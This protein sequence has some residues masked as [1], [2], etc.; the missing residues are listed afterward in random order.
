[1]SDR[2]PFQLNP[3][4]I[5]CEEWEA[6]LADA[7]DGALTDKDRASFD[8]HAAECASCSVMLV[9]AQKGQ[10]WLQFLHPEPPIP[11]GLLGKIIARTSGTDYDPGDRRRRR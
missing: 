6:L 10:Q 5:R 8:G 7:L 4:P 11:A 9:E 1:M 2:T 3:R